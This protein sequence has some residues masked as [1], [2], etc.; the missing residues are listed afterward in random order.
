MSRW[1][2]P[3]VRPALKSITDC[4]DGRCSLE[5]PTD[6]L[7]NSRR[8]RKVRPCP[9]C[10]GPVMELLSVNLSNPFLS[11]CCICCQALGRQNFGTSLL[12][13]G[14]DTLQRADGVFSIKDVW[15]WDLLG[16]HTSTDQQFRMKLLTLCSGLHEKNPT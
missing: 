14:R 15:K 4:N 6:L 13:V 9:P 12:A 11:Q 7:P 16:S 3:I 10:Q 2:L 1:P 5:E 8:C